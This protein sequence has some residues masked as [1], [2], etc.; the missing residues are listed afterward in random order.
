M[1]D[2]SSAFP[3]VSTTD[4][5]SGKSPSVPRLVTEAAET[6][7]YAAW[8]NAVPLLRSVSIDNT[9]G[10]ELS[11]VTVQLSVI[12]VGRCAVPDRRRRW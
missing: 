11:S 5:E 8:Q 3:H 2:G 1:Q 12:P 9:H 7:N 10:A 6:F 4:A